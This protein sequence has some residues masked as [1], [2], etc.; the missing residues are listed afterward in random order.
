MN[1]SNQCLYTVTGS[2]LLADGRHHKEGGSDLHEITIQD[3]ARCR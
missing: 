2:S 1:S 3:V